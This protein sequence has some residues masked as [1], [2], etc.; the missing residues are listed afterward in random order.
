MLQ[1]LLVRNL[2]L[3]EEAEVHFENGLNILS[4]ETGAGKSI[5]IGSITTALGARAARD[6]I[7]TGT[8]GAYV[9]LVFSVE[10]P[11]I[12]Q[13]LTEQDILLEDGQLILSRKI[14]S[15]KNICRIN[16]EAVPVAKLREIAALLLDL[17]GQHDHQ[18]LLER[19]RHLEILDQYGKTALDGSLN[20]VACLY[21]E[22]RTLEKTLESYGEDAESR[23]REMDFLQF[24]WD[25]IQEADLDPQEEDHLL[26]AFKKQNHMNQ[27]RQ[28]VE[29]GMQILENADDERVAILDGI[30]QM[31]HE[32][33]FIAAADE[34]FAPWTIRRRPGIDW[35]FFRIMKK[36]K[37]GWRK[38]MMP[39]GKN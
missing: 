23:K 16:G 2:A 7:R 22:Y 31:L 15:T 11:S 12:L 33:Q 30:G 38:D 4:G 36:K 20:Q 27:I 37:S 34:T 6:I 9:E 28:G 18:I 8:E 29:K 24:E 21:K 1:S 25:E 10:N 32:F 13:K 35:N 19:K 39:V 3:I 5:L 26:A 14:T 17:H